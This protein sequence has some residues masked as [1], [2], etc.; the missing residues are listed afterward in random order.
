MRVVHKS[1]LANLCKRSDL[2]DPSTHGWTRR[3]RRADRDARRRRASTRV[4]PRDQ[5]RRLHDGVRG[6]HSPSS[7]GTTQRLTLTGLPSSSTIRRHRNLQL[8]MLGCCL[9]LPAPS[10]HSRSSAHYVLRTRCVRWSYG[11]AAEG[12]C[13]GRD[14]ESTRYLVSARRDAACSSGCW[15]SV[16]V[17]RRSLELG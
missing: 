10:R 2:A 17:R 13:L 14:P 16:S 5:Q 7:S 3:A 11:L 15:C 12:R 4:D 6:A 1:I 8:G 9:R